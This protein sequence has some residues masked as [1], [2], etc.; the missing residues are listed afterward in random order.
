M[1]QPPGFWAMP[2]TCSQVPCRPLATTAAEASGRNVLAR[3]LDATP[4]TP[5]ATAIGVS[6]TGHHITLL[7]KLALSCSRKISAPVT[8]AAPADSPES[9]RSNR[10]CSMFHTRWSMPCRAGTRR[11]PPASQPMPLTSRLELVDAVAE[12]RRGHGRLV[13]LAPQPRLREALRLLVSHLA[14]HG[15]LIR[16]DHHVHQRR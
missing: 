13:R 11:R 15:R 8:S 1:R 5:A 9:A 10:P 16:V 6:A 12:Q 14:R 3:R 4:A 2:R 7:P